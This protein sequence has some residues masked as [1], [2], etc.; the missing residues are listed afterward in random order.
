[1]TVPVFHGGDSLSGSNGI[2]YSF[3]QF[4]DFHIRDAQKINDD[5]GG[6]KSWLALE[7]AH[8]NKG[9]SSLPLLQGFSRLSQMSPSSQEADDG[10]FSLPT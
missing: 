2:C 7:R 3:C 5:Q 9:G 8:F 4:C 10:S 1:M 6:K